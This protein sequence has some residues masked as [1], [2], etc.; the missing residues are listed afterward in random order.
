MD[1]YGGVP[2]VIVQDNL[3]SVVIKP[4]V[5]KLNSMIFLPPL[6]LITI[7][8]FSLREPTDQ[9]IKPGGRIGK[10]I[11]TTVFTKIVQQVYT[12]LGELNEAIYVHLKVH[13]NNLLIGYEYSRQQQFDTMEKNVL[14]PLNPYLYNPMDNKIAT[15][16]KK[17]KPSLL[18]SYLI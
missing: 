17:R 14:K 2:E 7:P 6:P 18:T 10:I 15:V 5:L 13:N 1:F 8:L 12:S 11:Y 3:K 4:A 9:S 16:G